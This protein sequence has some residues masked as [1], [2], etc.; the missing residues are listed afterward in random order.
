MLFLCGSQAI[1]EETDKIALNADESIHQTNFQLGLR[2]AKLKNWPK[3]AKSLNSKGT[4]RRLDWNWKKTQK[5]FDCCYFNIVEQETW[6][7]MVQ[8]VFTDYNPTL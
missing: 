3:K 2:K 7:F 4:D 1:R 5:V 8:P 6:E